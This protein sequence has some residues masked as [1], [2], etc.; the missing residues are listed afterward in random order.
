MTVSCSDKPSNGQRTIQRRGLERSHSAF[1][2]VGTVSWRKSASSYLAL[3]HWN[4]PEISILFENHRTCALTHAIIFTPMAWRCYINI[5]IYLYM[6]ICICIYVECTSVLLHERNLNTS[7]K[8]MGN[9]LSME[10]ATPALNWPFAAA[11]CLCV[12][13]VFN[14][15]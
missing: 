9:M 1:G 15:D 12:C 14:C 10:L 6:I 4:Y 3:R 2:S 13:H 5:Y 8:F 7:C 11:T